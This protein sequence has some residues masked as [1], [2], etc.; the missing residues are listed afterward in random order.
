MRSTVK[1]GLAAHGI[2]SI[3]VHVPAGIV[4]SLVRPLLPDRRFSHDIHDPLLNLA[5]LGHIQ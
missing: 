1:A 4:I 3:L 2:C 5:D